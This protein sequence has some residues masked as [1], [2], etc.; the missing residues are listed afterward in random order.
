MAI[1]LQVA[2]PDDGDVEAHL[3]YWSVVLGLSRSEV[4]KYMEIGYMLGRMP[5]LAAECAGRGHLS[6]R[7]LAMLGRHTRPVADDKIDAVEPGLMA[8]VKPR[9]DGE[10]LRGVQALAV[11]VQRVLDECVPEVRPRDIDVVGAQAD[12]ALAQNV[13]ATVDAAVEVLADV[14]AYE[15]DGADVAAPME[16]PEVCE[17]QAVALDYFGDR[18]T[19]REFVAVDDRDTTGATTVTAVLERHHAVE[20]MAIVDAVAAKLK[21]NRAEAFMHAL[22]GTCDVEVN[23]ELFRVLTPGTDGTPENTPVWLSGAGWLSPLAAE[24]WMNRVSTLRVLGDSAVEGYRPSESQRAFVR[25]RDGVCSFPGCDVPAER[26]DIDHI[27]EFNHD[28]APGERLQEASTHTDNLH[29]LCRRHHNLKTAG[30]WRVVRGE[31][32]VEEWT[33]LSCDEG[34]FAKSGKA[35]TGHGRYTFASQT[36]KKTAAL[37][38]HNERRRKLHDKLRELVEKVQREVGKNQSAG[39]NQSDG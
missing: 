27:V 20:A 8:V 18:M 14:A 3:A 34:P 19:P 12:Q 36:E 25:A 15:L 33:F 23:L 22:R 13:D 38:E 7:H 30:M 31:G 24:S 6:L 29:C 16:S 5:Q 4:N 9:R 10:A 1:A 26:C 28:L 37:V 2:P 39:E 21:V 32:G 11:R 35:H 17:V